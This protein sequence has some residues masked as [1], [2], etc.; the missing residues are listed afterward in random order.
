MILCVC[1]GGGG[2]D[3]K[4][5]FA[6]MRSTLDASIG[7]CETPCGCLELNLGPLED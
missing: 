5:M 1:G 4:C 2:D 3:S 7:S 6:C